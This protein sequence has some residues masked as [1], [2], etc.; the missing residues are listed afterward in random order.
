M[1]ETYFVL[2]DERQEPDRGMLERGNNKMSESH[3]STNNDEQPTSAGGL[4]GEG[5]PLTGREAA[6]VARQMGEMAASGLPLSG[7]LR[8]MAEELRPRDPLR[9]RLNVMADDLDAGV[10]LVEVLGSQGNA[11]PAHF[12]GVGGSRPAFR[13]FTGAAG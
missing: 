10:P 8:A 12:S 4:A 2:W 11:F 7:G 1:K 3:V 5:R 6:E 9:R 13:A